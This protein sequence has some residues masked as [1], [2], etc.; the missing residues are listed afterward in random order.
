MHWHTYRHSKWQIC[1][2]F[3]SAAKIIDALVFSRVR[4]CIQVY[5]S[6]NR[7]NICKL[8]N[9]FN[10][11][12]RIISGRRKFDHI[13]CVL[14]QLGWL[15]IHELVKCFDVNLLHGILCIGEPNVL[16]SE[17][18][19]NH[20][21]IDRETRQSHLSL[22]QVRNNRGKRQYMYRAVQSYNEHVISQGLGNVPKTRL[23]T[24]LE[25]YSG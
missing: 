18:V 17:L 24:N 11:A 7:S 21:R 25:T 1:A 20:E 8:Q 5:G 15:S 19:F 3:I 9:I 2:P 13:F 4:Y 16:R 22:P 10:F 23:K 14:H 12:A 6:A